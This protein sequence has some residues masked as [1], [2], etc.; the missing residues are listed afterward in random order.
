MPRFDFEGRQRRAVAALRAVPYCLCVALLAPMLPVHAQEAAPASAAVAT[1]SLAPP[2]MVLVP[3]GRYAA[4]TTKD[5]AQALRKA[6]RIDKGDQERFEQ[7]IAR[8]LIRDRKRTVEVDAFYADLYEVP[9]LQYH[10]YREA[11]AA[12]APLL[13]RGHP[14]CWREGRAPGMTS[15]YFVDEVK[16]WPDLL[17]RI[18]RQKKSKRAWPGTRIHEALDPEVRKAVDAARGGAEVTDTLKE[19]L[20]KE[21]NRLLALPDFYVASSWAGL[22]MPR[23]AAGLLDKGEKRTASE[24]AWLNRLLMDRHFGSAVEAGQPP[25][26]KFCPVTGITPVQAKRC[27]EWMGKR[28]ASEHEWEKLAR[29]EASRDGAARWYP[30]GNEFGK[31][32]TDVCNWALFWLDQKLNPDRTPP[33][34]TPVGAFPKGASPFGALDMIGNAVEMTQSPWGKHPNAESGVEFTPSPDSGSVVVKGGAFGE[35]FKLNLRVPWRHPMKVG[36]AFE[37]VG[38]R[39]VKDLAVGQ[40]VLAR[41]A[42]EQFSAL[43]G[44]S[45]IAKETATLERTT[46][47]EG[48]TAPTIITKYEWV[49]FVGV[50]AH[51][52][53][54]ARA[55]DSASDKVKRKKQ[56]GKVFIGV[57]HL[58]SRFSNPPLEPGTYAIMY[59]RGFPNAKLMNENA[60]RRANPNAAIRKADQKAERKK[61]KGKGKDKDKDKGGKKDGPAP[62]PAP[63]PAPSP[64]PNAA[65]AAPKVIPIYS[66]V[67]R[68]LFVNASGKIVAQIEN[69]TVDYVKGAPPTSVTPITPEGAPAALLVHLAMLKKYERTRYLTVDFKLES[70]ERGFAEGWTRNR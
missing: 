68:I 66:K 59:Q 62:A 1:D 20:V 46:Y 42:E 26:S 5:E 24:T 17:G 41:A 21:L 60:A 45:R 47:L 30:W 63:A 48:Q 65:P 40:S 36:E 50:D 51:N 4:G 39:C 9:I 28:L 35:Q 43:R 31:T 58:P 56:Q 52:F 54:S 11:T 29:G 3:A 69:P 7:T 67:P 27:A 33:S 8:E 37:G 55:L 18:G 6:L 34:L 64:E 19:A 53:G 16:S 10:Y 25:E 57:C 22:S 12:A 15:N 13:D 38:F 2:G 44:V 32:E 61:D 49:G 23:N 14:L 70:A